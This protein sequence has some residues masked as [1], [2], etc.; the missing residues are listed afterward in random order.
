MGTRVI[1]IATLRHH[2]AQF[3]DAAAALEEWH[4]IVKST[5]FALREDLQGAFPKV[6]FVSPDYV[7]FNILG[8]HYRLIATINYMVPVL[9]LKEFLPHHLYDAWLPDTQRLNQMGHKKAV[10][11]KAAKR[12]PKKK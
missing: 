5:I 2:Q 3:P 12:Q 1:A 9:Y 11:K 10:D 4:R 8:G 6:S 7:I